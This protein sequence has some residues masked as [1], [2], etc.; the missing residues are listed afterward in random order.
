M[1]N[2]SLR[3]KGD[4]T[5]TAKYR[6]LYILT[7]HWL[8]DL[9]FYKEDLHFLYHLV[10]KYFISL[11]NKENLEEMRNLSSGLSETSINCD[12]LLEKTSKHLTHLAELIDDPFKYDS[13]KFRSEHEELENEI[14]FFV[15]KFRKIKKE[16]FTDMEPVIQK[17]VKKLTP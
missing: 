4:F 1:E 7:E 13:H 2:F 8:S 6:E 3:P 12:R 5:W 15:K 16:T 17:E 11:I 14:S 10:D 9:K